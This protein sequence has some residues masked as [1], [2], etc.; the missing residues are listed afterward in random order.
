MYNLADELIPV[1]VSHNITSTTCRFP[2]RDIGP[3]GT[4]VT[5]VSMGVSLVFVGM[6]LMVFASTRAWGWDDILIAVGTVWSISTS[7][8]RPLN[9]A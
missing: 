6:Q 5:F 7:D 1:T 4:A 2:D 9:R 8:A 3:S